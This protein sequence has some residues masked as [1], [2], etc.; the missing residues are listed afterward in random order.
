MKVED[1]VET[2]DAT[3][4]ARC[5]ASR[6]RGAFHQLYERHVGVLLGFA[7]RV[8]GDGALAEDVVQES[9]V[10]L[11]QSIDNVDV[12][13]PLRPY[14]FK[15]THHVALRALGRRKKAEAVAEEAATPG[16][17]A[18]SGVLGVVQR[19]EEKDLVRDCL[20]RLAP[21]YRSL[22]VLRHVEGMKL[23]ELAEVL[24]CTERTVRNRLRSAAALFGRELDRR[25]LGVDR[26]GK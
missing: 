26:E 21:E 12:G 25:G 23:A 20:A 4:L 7:R 11:F 9:F 5:Q 18:G 14:L 16:E 13:R 2:E 10:R 19:A 6:D 15:I 22:M 8:T 17:K 1:M 24:D 3:L